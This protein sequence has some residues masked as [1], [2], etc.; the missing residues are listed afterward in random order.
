M[1]PKHKKKNKSYARYRWRE[2]HKKQYTF[3]K[4]KFVAG[5]LISLFTS[6]FLGSYFDKYGSIVLRQSLDA[7]RS[8]WA[9]DSGEQEQPVSTA[10]AEEGSEKLSE[11]RAELEHVV[12]SNEQDIESIEQRAKAVRVSPNLAKRKVEIRRAAPSYS[13][14]G[15]SENSF[16]KEEKTKEA[17][18]RHSIGE[19]EAF[20]F[21]APPR[22]P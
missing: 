14:L 3:T 10:A 18:E 2:K 5:F 15:F 13:G 22:K 9:E 19:F 4:T 6:I 8:A 20:S 11:E 7:I 17:Q 12:E 1:K 21:D 16:P